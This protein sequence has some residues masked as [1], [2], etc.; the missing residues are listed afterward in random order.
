MGKTGTMHRATAGGQ[1]LA[2]RLRSAHTHWTRLR[3]LLGTKRLEP[4]EG[5]WIKPSNQIHMFGMRYALDLVFLDA[6]RRV[7]WLVH[8]LAPNRISPRVAGATSVLELPPGTL[9]R[10][11]VA[12]G[13]LVE[14]DAEAGAPRASRL[15]VV[16]LLGNVA[17]AA[18]FGLFAG[19]Q[20]RAAV[21]TGQW[22]T[23]MPI[24]LQETLLVVLFLTRR[25]C[26][27][28][29]DRPLDWIVGVIGT[30]LPLLMRPD[31]VRGP[32]N[33]LGE[34][35]QFLGVAAAVVA[36]SFL[37]RSFGVVA[38]NRGVKTSGLYRI[39]RHPTYAGYLLSYVGY[40]MCYPTSGNLMVAIATLLAFNA[41]AIFEERL[42]RRDPAYRTYQ[43]ATP[44]RFVP[45]VY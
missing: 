25:C 4:G 31:A 18:I 7:V 15:D 3:G 19:S 10:I 44:W 1:V 22:A 13:D 30:V 42:L 34:P 17:L 32:L 5:L 23:T 45:Y 14:I 2:D 20:V 35:L 29:S 27:A 11:A 6:S 37:G 40:V 16:A 33:W 41:R 12:E 36:L 9:E 43:L 39:V 26:F 28:T 38:A 8:A 21:S 24:A